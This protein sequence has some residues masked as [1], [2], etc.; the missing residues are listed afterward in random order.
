MQEI[1]RNIPLLLLFKTIQQLEVKGVKI[2]IIKTRQQLSLE[3]IYNRISKRLKKLPYNLKSW[4]HPF[5]GPLL[6]YHSL[7]VLFNLSHETLQYLVLVIN[8]LK[9]LILQPVK[10]NTLNWTILNQSQICLKRGVILIPTVL[11][12]KSLNR[13]VYSIFREI[14]SSFK[15]KIN[16]MLLISIQIRTIQICSNENLP[17]IFS[18]REILDKIY[19]NNQTKSKKNKTTS[20]TKKLQAIKIPLLGMDQRI[21]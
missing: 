16:H 4:L 21:N 11:F 6:P 12:T 13:T 18:L 17:L 19:S 7:S 5:W 3:I 20:K 15:T 1:R 14:V 8:Y 9:L 2:Q 10:I